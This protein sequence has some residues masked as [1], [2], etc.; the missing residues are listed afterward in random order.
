LLNN[1]F[2]ELKAVCSTLGVQSDSWV[3]EEA[4]ISQVEAACSLH[5]LEFKSHLKPLLKSIADNLVSQLLTV[6]CVSLLLVR[7]VKCSNKEEHSE[8][9]DSAVRIIGNPWLNRPAWDANV[10]NDDARKMVDAW[11]KQKLIFDFFSLLSEDGAVDQRRLKYWLRYHTVI[12]DMWFALGPHARNNSNTDFKEF[13]DRARGRLLDLEFAGMSVNN[14]F[15]L[16]LGELIV[17]EFGCKGNACYIYQCNNFPVELGARRWVH[18]Y[19]DLRSKRFGEQFVHRDGSQ[20]WEEKLDNILSPLLA[21]RPSET[22]SDSNRNPISNQHTNSGTIRRKAATQLPLFDEHEFYKF[23]ALNNLTVRD[24]RIKGG[25][26]WVI[27][28]MTDQNIN[29]MLKDFGFNYKYGR[30]WWKE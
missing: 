9:R 22:P 4:I 18:G 13:R 25:A 12:N 6:R 26:L 7:Y 1:D 14:A 2:A 21:W 28:H 23:T 8:L 17:V 11:L 27:T 3:W 10:K 16:C 5:D 15:I 30:G 29:K 24:S 19:N 20:K